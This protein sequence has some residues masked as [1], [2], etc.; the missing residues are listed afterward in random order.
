MLQV[1]PALA[2]SIWIGDLITNDLTPLNLNTWFCPE[3]S[4][5]YTKE[6]ELE[7]GLWIMD[8][9]PM[10]SGILNPIEDNYLHT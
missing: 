4:H 3:R 6:S 5:N 9:R 1:L 10:K 7:K 2:A 8:G